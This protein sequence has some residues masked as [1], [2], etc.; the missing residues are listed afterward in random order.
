MKVGEEGVERGDWSTHKIDPYPWSFRKCH[1]TK[2]PNPDQDLKS[3][4]CIGNRCLA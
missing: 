1:I 3:H 2:V 4:S